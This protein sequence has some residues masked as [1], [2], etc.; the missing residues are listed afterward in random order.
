M[1]IDSIFCGG[2]KEI[3]R[4]RKKLNEKT[5]HTPNYGIAKQQIRETEP[6]SKPIK[7]N[8]PTSNEIETLDDGVY[9]M[10][11]MMMKTATNIMQKLCAYLIFVFCCNAFGS[12]NGNSIVLPSH[13]HLNP[14]HHHP[15]QQHQ[16]NNRHLH[17]NSQHS[18]ESRLQL[19]LLQHN[20]SDVPTKKR[21]NFYYS[22]LSRTQNTN[23][24]NRMNE[25]NKSHNIA[26]ESNVHKTIRSNPIAN[27]TL[28]SQSNDETAF[29]ANVAKFEQRNKTTISTKPSLN[30]LKLT[31]IQ[32][33]R[34]YPNFNRWPIAT[35]Q[36]TIAEPSYPLHGNDYGYKWKPAND[37]FVPSFKP[38]F[39]SIPNPIGKTT[40]PT[41]NDFHTR[42]HRFHSKHHRGYVM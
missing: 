38:T 9:T 35:P 36:T 27:Q 16:H 31:L 24:Y 6:Y 10:V 39:E 26:D 15:H 41:P 33:N 1:N 4:E 18:D 2:E 12:M 19:Q 14:H 13:S 42:D 21:I 30:S 20:N 29:N 8:Y 11:T 7:F 5:N 34:N 37:Q 23:P 25:N 28:Q 40:T 22:S 3:K 17:L 32:T